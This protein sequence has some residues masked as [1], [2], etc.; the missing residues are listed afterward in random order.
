MTYPLENDDEGLLRFETGPQQALGRLLE[1]AD[2][3]AIGPGL[4]QSDEIRELVHW[5][6]EEVSSRPCSTPT[7]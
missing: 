5:V 1:R 4:G 7:P 6:V 3:L 2:V